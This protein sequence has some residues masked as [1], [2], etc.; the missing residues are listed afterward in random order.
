[1]LAYLREQED[2][3][4]SSA[5]S[6][7]GDYVPNNDQDGSDDD[8][9]GYDNHSDDN[10]LQ[11][12]NDD[13]DDSGSDFE[14]DSQHTA[15]AGHFVIIDP[16]LQEEVVPSI[17]IEIGEDA[18]DEA[19]E[20]VED[21]EDDNDEEIIEPDDE[22]IQAA[23]NQVD[24]TDPS[25][26]DVFED[27]AFGIDSSSDSETDAASE[28]SPSPTEGESTLV[29]QQHLISRR[30]QDSL[31]Q[32]QESPISQ[33]EEDAPSE[34]AADEEVGFDEI[35]IPDREW[36]ESFVSLF[37]A[38]AVGAPNAGGRS[39]AYQPNHAGEVTPRPNTRIE[40]NHYDEE[41]GAYGHASSGFGPGVGYASNR[42]GFD[43]GLD[44]VDVMELGE[45]FVR[46]DICDPDSMDTSAG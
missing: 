6:T 31:S 43:V 21:L 28:Y 18:A 5:S 17:A 7:A 1:M 35:V 16:D 46:E 20:D 30:E 45:V 4:G 38:P 19:D 2:A 42:C 14:D 12:S 11:E 37:T 9:D 27:D 36:F 25:E 26:I 44:L 33:T 39:N 34:S 41:A 8:S 10:D 29:Y 22:K 23:A 24:V 13:F 32:W 40:P 15:E 3:Q